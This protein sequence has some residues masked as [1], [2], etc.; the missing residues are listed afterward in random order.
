M[1]SATGRGSEDAQGSGQASRKHEC[2]I[3]S[4]VFLDTPFQYP[5]CYL[6]SSVF[7]M[8]IATTQLSEKQ[9][10]KSWYPNSLLQCLGQDQDRQSQSLLGWGRTQLWPEASQFP[11]ATTATSFDAIKIHFIISGLY[12]LH[13]IILIQMGP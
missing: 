5:H 13:L 7:K 3:A 11:E 6:L 8:L 10:H 1:A 2:H 12:S 9:R 4:G